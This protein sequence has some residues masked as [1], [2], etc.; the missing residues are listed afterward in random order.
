MSMSRNLKALKLQVFKVS[1][2]NFLHFL[3]HE[4]ATFSLCHEKQDNVQQLDDVCGSVLVDLIA[5]IFTMH[6]Q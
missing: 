1:R 2:P 5:V 4:K 6:D 3:K